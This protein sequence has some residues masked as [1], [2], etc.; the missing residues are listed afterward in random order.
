MY[1]VDNQKIDFEVFTI[2]WI[3]HWG[4]G[5]CALEKTMINCVSVNVFLEKT[6][7]TCVNVNVLKGIFQ[8]AR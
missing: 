5:E 8:L 4:G 1:K 2:D 3:K 6:I 7:I